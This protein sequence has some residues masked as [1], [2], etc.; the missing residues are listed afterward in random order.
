MELSKEEALKRVEKLPK[1]RRNQQALVKLMHNID[2]VER[3]VWEV[4][5]GKKLIEYEDE[6]SLPLAVFNWLRMYPSFERL[7]VSFV[8]GYESMDEITAMGL[9]P[10]KRRVEDFGYVPG[11]AN[12]AWTTKGYRTMADM[13]TKYLLSEKHK[14][15]SVILEKDGM[16]QV[17]DASNTFDPDNEH[18]LPVVITHRIKKH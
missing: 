14:T 8:G 11:Q 1:E 7:E 6:E 5:G 12:Y 17:Y 9:K 15:L 4:P 13:I 10:M 16:Y 2:G 3:K 18:W